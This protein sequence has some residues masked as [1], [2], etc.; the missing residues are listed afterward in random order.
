M[1][2]SFSATRAHVALDRDAD[3]GLAG[4]AELQR[5]GDRDDLHD[6]R[7]AQAL[8][9]AAHRRLGQPDRLGDGAVGLAP[10]ALQRL[11]DGPVGRVEEGARRLHRVVLAARLHRL[12]GVGHLTPRFA[13][14]I[15]GASPDLQNCVIFTRLSQAEF[16]TLRVPILRKRLLAGVIICDPVA[17]GPR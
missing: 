5:V 1:A 8:D 4:E 3:H 16:V 17:N 10:V 14:R 7:L 11:D 6:P 15:R 13:R 9:P 2:E 12:L